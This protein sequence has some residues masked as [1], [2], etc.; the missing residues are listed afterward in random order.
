MNSTQ[1]TLV[2]I[3]SAAIRNNNIE[4]LDVSNINWR[5]VFDEAK[6]HAVYPLIYPLVKTISINNHLNEALIN[7]WRDLTLTSGLQQ[8]YQINQIKKVFTSFSEEN[9]DIIAL[10]GLVLRE[11]YPHPELRTMCDADVLI[12]KE[13]I[14]VAE[15]ILKNL[16]YIKFGS[17]N[18]HHSFKNENHLLI[19]LH[20]SLMDEEHIKSIPDFEETLWQNTR[21]VAM[22]G[23]SVL[24]LSLEYE[25]LHILLHIASHM[26]KSSFG[27]RQLCDIVVFIESEKN[28]INWDLF[29]EK[30]KLYNIEKFVMSLFIVCKELFG[31]TLPEHD[32]IHYF[33]YNN[34]IELLINEV[35]SSAVYGYKDN[36][37]RNSSNIVH[38][39]NNNKSTSLNRIKLLIS[40]LFPSVEKMSEKYYYAKKYK[41]LVL[42]AWIHRFIYQLYKNGFS[43][44]KQITSMHLTLNHAKGRLK[45][46]RWLQLF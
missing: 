13:N 39:S 40:F 17:T 41:F 4:K 25:L 31:M 27:L 16:G 5:E 44:L 18:I 12:H 45:L 23:I 42:F 36:I 33:Q 26:V 7:E 24:S 19:D 14:E 11:V 3:L 38:Y 10:K 22:N 28:N 29:F 6:A 8:I 21:V 32:S 46:I 37:I 20:F 30:I 2:D 9:I 34:Y 43:A 35:F 1:K 15:K